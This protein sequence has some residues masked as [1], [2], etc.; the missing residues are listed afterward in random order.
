MSPYRLRRGLPYMFQ[1]WCR[2]HHFSSHAHQC[3]KVNNSNSVRVCFPSCPLFASFL[4]MY[5][6]VLAVFVRCPDNN[7]AENKF[8]YIFAEME[9]V[10][11]RPYILSHSMSMLYPGCNKKDNFPIRAFGGRGRH[12]LLAT[13]KRPRPYT[14]MCHPPAMTTQRG[15]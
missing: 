6:Q 4:H 12:G 13:M 11:S 14:T 15:R 7:L 5:D 10:N 8:S 3:L 9:P 2:R 1:V